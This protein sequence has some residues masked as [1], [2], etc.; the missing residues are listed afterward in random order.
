MAQS[1]GQPIGILP[2]DE[3]Q[4]ANPYVALPLASGLGPA[5]NAVIARAAVAL[6]AVGGGHG[7]LSEMA[8]GLQFGRLVIALE[9][10]P[11]V[12][13]ALRFETLDSALGRVAQRI[14]GLDS[15]AP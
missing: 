13:G 14:L 11:G 3:W 6:L 4:E 7:T 15:Q 5:R 1:G 8:F 9:D 10:A 2:G 12:P